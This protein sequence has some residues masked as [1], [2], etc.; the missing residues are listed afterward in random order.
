MDSCV[1]AEADNLDGVQVETEEEY[2]PSN[3]A[4]EELSS[5]LGQKVTGSTNSRPEPWQL[6]DDAP[7]AIE[8]VVMEDAEQSS[9]AQSLCNGSKHPITELTNSRH[10]AS[11]RALPS[12]YATPSVGTLNDGQ[13]NHTPTTPR[14]TGSK[15]E[16]MTCHMGFKEGDTVQIRWAF[17]DYSFCVGEV[18]YIRRIVKDHHVHFLV[19]LAAA[20]ARTRVEEA[21]LKCHTYL[22]EWHS[23]KTWIRCCISQ[24]E[25]EGH[26]INNS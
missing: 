21:N 13:A 1:A 16:E 22:Y 18:G 6:E 4:G 3:G 9:S 11:P 7:R 10:F 24:L 20:N 8:S 12:G 5:G 26:R 23:D 25:I 19:E 14:L 15:H 2:H 17:R